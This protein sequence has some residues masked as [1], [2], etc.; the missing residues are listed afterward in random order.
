M[1]KTNEKKI[2]KKKNIKRKIKKSKRKKYITSMWIMGNY[3][4]SLNNL[5]I[6][7]RSS[8]ITFFRHECGWTESNRDKPIA[9]PRKTQSLS[10]L[11]HHSSLW[12]RSWCQE[13]GSWVESA[14][15]K[16]T[17]PSYNFSL[18]KLFKINDHKPSSLWA[19]SR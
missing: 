11:V 12:F 4:T 9:P 7:H 3:C 18:S 17:A 13:E 19:T 2:Q 14:L 15:Y 6:Y 10:A 16:L 1:G 5:Q 8:E